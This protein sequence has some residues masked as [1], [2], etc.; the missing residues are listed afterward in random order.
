VILVEAGQRL[1]KTFDPSLSVLA[2]QSLRRRILVAFER[3]EAEPDPAQLSLVPALAV[4]SRNRG[5][6]IDQRDLARGSGQPLGRGQPA[7][8]GAHN[9]DAR[10][11]DDWNGFFHIPPPPEAFRSGSSFICGGHEG[12]KDLGSLTPGL[13]WFLFFSVSPLLLVAALAGVTMGTTT[14][15]RITDLLMPVSRG[16]WCKPMLMPPMV[17]C[18]GTIVTAQSDVI[19]K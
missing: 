2:L 15:S 17:R 1:L 9:H 4:S 13:F 14:G 18:A 6:P 3:A 8:A 11:S 16:D 5:S 19:G 7:K 10:Y 12:P